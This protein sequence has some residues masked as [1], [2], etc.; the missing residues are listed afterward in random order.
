MFRVLRIRGE[1]MSPKYQ[2]GDFVLLRS[3]WGGRFKRGDVIAF[4]NQLYGTLIK[5]INKI[6]D[7]GIYV[8]GTGENSLDSRRLGPV[9]PDVVVGKVIWHIHR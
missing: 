7:E 2:S 1:S 3:V 9:N 8:L 6:T 5:R 4:S